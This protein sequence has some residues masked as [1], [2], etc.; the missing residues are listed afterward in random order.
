M[1]LGVYFSIIAIILGLRLIYVS[2]KDNYTEANK[3]L[4]KKIGKIF[5]VL[6][7]TLLIFTII[8]FYIL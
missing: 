2:H 8:V 5:L 1:W 7:F 6:G 4:Y 3:K